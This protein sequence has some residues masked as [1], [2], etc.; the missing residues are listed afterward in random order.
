MRGPLASRTTSASRP[1]LP[2]SKLLNEAG[3]VLI[4]QPMDRVVLDLH[5]SG[6]GDS[7]VP[8]PLTGALFSVINHSVP[9]QPDRA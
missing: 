7:S 1:G 8:E 5:G 6:G 3:T 4:D 9:P 2:M